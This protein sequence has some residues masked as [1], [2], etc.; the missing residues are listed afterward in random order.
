VVPCVREALIRTAVHPILNAA[1]NKTIE[2]IA[3][4]ALIH[5]DPDSDFG[6]SFPDF[7]NRISA[8]SSIDQAIAMAKRALT[9]HLEGSLAENETIPSPA[10]PEAIHG[11]DTIFFA[12]IEVPEARVESARGGS[13]TTA[14]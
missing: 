14:G 2:M 12:A 3:Y 9:L 13:G 4:I 5:K 10:D 1:F 8:G 11:N 7:P 6:V